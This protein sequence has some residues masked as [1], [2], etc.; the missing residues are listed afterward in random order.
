[1]FELSGF[2]PEFTQWVRVLMNNT[3]S[4][5]GYCGWLSAFSPGNSGIQQG[6][7][8][9]PLAFVL[10]VELL[11][12]KI[13]QSPNVKGIC[14]PT[15]YGNTAIKLAMYADDT[16]LL[17]WDEND[18]QQALKIVEDFSI[19]SGLLPNRNK[20]KAMSI[21]KDISGDPGGIRWIKKWLHENSRSLFQYHWENQ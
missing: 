4:C 11:A 10:A 20:T 13:R 7:P 5:I 3:E 8:F 21:G 9:S 18:V 17:M 1:M 15:A 2:G 19:F 16:T 6:C 12:H 14:I